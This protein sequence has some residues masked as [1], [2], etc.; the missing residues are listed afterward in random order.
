MTV[1]EGRRTGMPD[2]RPFATKP[3]L[4]RQMLERT[5]AAGVPL[6]GIVGD[7][8]YG[9]D[10]ALRNW[11]E[12][13]RHAYV[14]AVS[15]NAYVWRPPPQQ[16]VSAIRTELPVEGWERLSAGA[17]SNGPRWDDWMRLDLHAPAAA[18]FTRWLL[19]RRSISAPTEVT[20]YATYAP[21]VTTLPQRVRV[22][23]MRWTVEASI[24]TGKGEGGLD[25]DEVR[26]WT[27]WYRHMTLAMWAPAF[28]RVVRAEP[29]VP[30]APKKGRRI[31]AGP[32]RLMTFNA[33][34]GLHSG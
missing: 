29:G 14:L 23:G 31:P 4:A 13:R 24:Q 6:T 8:V 21:T 7:S 10:R 1:N 15:G 25:H 5:V 26:A 12:A 22:A 30:V 28:L 18:D 19:V 27:G 9:D 32:S 2:D 20:A 33:R 3:A 16:R 34:R 17:G 11:R